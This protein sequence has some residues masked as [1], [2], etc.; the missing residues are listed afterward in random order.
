MSTLTLDATPRLDGDRSVTAQAGTL[1]EAAGRGVG[2]AGDPEVAAVAKRRQF[3]DDYKRRILAEISATPGK[4][5]V[6][7]RREG[8]YSS[9]L[10]KWRKKRGEMSTQPK[11]TSTNKKMHNE[12][13]KLQRENTRLKMKLQKAEGLI[14]LQKKTSELLDLMSRNGSDES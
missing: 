2:R 6:I 3:S 4:T 10:T 9:N 8:L 14:E 12:M 7:L 11:P 1:R 5:G 13:A